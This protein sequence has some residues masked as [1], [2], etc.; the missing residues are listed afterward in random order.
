M[1]KNILPDHNRKVGVITGASSGIG[2]A[3]ADKISEYFNHL[4]ILG[5]NIKGLEEA[6][7]KILENECECTIVPLNLKKNDLIKELATQIFIK[8]KKLDLL[9]SAAGVIHNL[10]PITSIKEVDLQELFE[11]NVL[12]NVMLLKYFQ[13][14]LKLSD[15]SKLIVIS[16]ELGEKI[17]PFWGGYTSIEKALNHLTLTFAEEN[18]DTNISTN[19]VCPR[20]V[21]SEFR[22][23]FLPGEDKTKLMTPNDFANQF[24]KL[25]QNQLETNG[26]IYTI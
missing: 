24:I 20:G 3:L 7:D 6:N 8:E 12:S 10:S 9:V 26:Q 23:I 5:R 1:Q 21:N 16:S 18:K 17:K 4:Y 15:N 11:I 22:N 19:I 2:L 25:Y 13:P 14:L